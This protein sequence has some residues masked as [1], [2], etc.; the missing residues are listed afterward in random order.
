MR[1]DLRVVRLDLIDRTGSLELV[2]GSGEFPAGTRPN[3]HFF[4]RLVVPIM[5]ALQILMA[6]V[7]SIPLA[8]FSATQRSTLALFAGVSIFLGSP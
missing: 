2:E 3:L 5:L 6:K 7:L 1:I 4:F 8:V